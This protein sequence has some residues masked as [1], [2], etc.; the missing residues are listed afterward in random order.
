MNVISIIS[1]A[2]VV[3][4]TSAVISLYLNGAVGVK[5]KLATL[6]DR[7]CEIEHLLRLQDDMPLHVREAKEG[8]HTLSQ[9]LGEI[10]GRLVTVA[11]GQQFVGG[12]LET[13]RS[14]VPL[15]VAEGFRLVGESVSAQGAAARK[16]A[17]ERD[18]RHS[19]AILAKI[20]SGSSALTEAVAQMRRDTA[21]GLQAGTETLAA[22]V[23]SLRQAMEG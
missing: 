13:L 22:N 5:Q 7:L 20:D 6:D 23:E 16:E 3:V 21:A 2:L 8:I 10:K 18:D 4:S 19:L 12:L 11:E 15:Q 1:L 9:S 14:S 17:S